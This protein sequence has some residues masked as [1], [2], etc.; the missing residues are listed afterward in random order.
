MANQ[1]DQDQLSQIVAAVLN[2]LKVQGAP[3]KAAAKPHFLPKGSAPESLEAKDRRILNIFAKRGFK[4]VVLRDRNNPSADHNVKSFKLWLES[5]R[6]VRRGSKSALGL[7]HIDQTDPLPGKA[8]PSPKKG[9][10]QLVKA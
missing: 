6:V 3:P 7:F 2:V 9:K 1:L 8:S 4:N 10:R 5:G